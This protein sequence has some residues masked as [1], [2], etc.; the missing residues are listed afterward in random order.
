MN[1]YLFF[2][3]FS[4]SHN[5]YLFEL[6]WYNTKWNNLAE[7]IENMPVQHILVENTTERK[8]IEQKSYIDTSIA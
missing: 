3:C 2:F 4:L 6:F 5:Y 1:T 7:V 8:T